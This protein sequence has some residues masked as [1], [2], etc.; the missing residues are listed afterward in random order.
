MAGI[1]RRRER[2]AA[3][4]TYGITARPRRAAAD[5]VGFRSGQR[6]AAA[7]RS[8]GR[9]RDADHARDRA[10]AAADHIQLHHPAAFDDTGGRGRTIR[11][12]AMSNRRIAI[13]LAVS[14][15][16]TASVRAQEPASA[17]PER[18][19]LPILL[20]LVVERSPRLAVEQVAIDT[21]EAERITACFFQ[22]EDG[23]RGVAVTGVQTCALPI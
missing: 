8:G 14:A 19:T 5:G 18:L 9:G 21:A 15:M 2:A 10:V 7:L 6:D 13:L 20:R 23:I 3:T 4:G 1:D 11:G 16:S 17:L 12:Q 22:T